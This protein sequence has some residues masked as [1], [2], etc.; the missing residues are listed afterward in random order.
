MFES[1]V[2]IRI[3]CKP[4]KDNHLTT[5]HSRVMRT[6]RVATVHYDYQRVKLDPPYPSACPPHDTLM[7][8]CGWP[9]HYP[10]YIQEVW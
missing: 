1:I 10:L 2:V 8:I 5:R 7:G 4:R 3:N 9:T 6:P